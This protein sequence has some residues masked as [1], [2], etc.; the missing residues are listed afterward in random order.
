MPEVS[1]AV[2]VGSRVELPPCAPEW[3]LAKQREAGH[4]CPRR[5]LDARNYLASSLL[6]CASDE[7]LVPLFDA[8]WESH[9]AEMTSTERARLSSR[10]VRAITDRAVREVVRRK[11][12]VAQEQALAAARARSRGGRG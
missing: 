9:T 4:P 11:R 2:E 12:E 1:W 8:V 6:L 10:V 3:E 7:Q 5:E